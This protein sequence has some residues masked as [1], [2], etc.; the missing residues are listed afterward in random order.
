MPRS[1]GRFTAI[2]GLDLNVAY[3][4]GGEPVGA[5]DFTAE[6]SDVNGD[7]TNAV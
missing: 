6:S 5:V 1:P 3:T 2:D 7:F 4:T